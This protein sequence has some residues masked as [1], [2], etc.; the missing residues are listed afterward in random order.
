MAE[1]LVIKQTRWKIARAYN[2]RWRR[3]IQN[4]YEEVLHP[5]VRSADEHKITNRSTR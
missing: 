5:R 3:L 4:H 2:N 1:K